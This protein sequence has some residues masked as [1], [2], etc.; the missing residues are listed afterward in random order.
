MNT[1]QPYRGVPSE[2]SI[3][4]TRGTRT[5]SEPL[6]ASVSVVADKL[7]QEGTFP[8]PRSQ[9]ARRS[10]RGVA[11]PANVSALVL[12]AGADTDPN[13]V[14]H[15]PCRCAPH[16]HDELGFSIDAV[17]RS[18]TGSIKPALSRS[19]RLLRDRLRRGVRLGRLG[20][21]PSKEWAGVPLLPDRRRAMDLRF[22]RESTRWRSRSLRSYAPAP[23]P[24]RSAKAFKFRTAPPS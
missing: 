24:T 15:S 23:R 22:R 3:E 20:A 13:Y 21:T 2:G 5:S 16:D 19:D 1:T 4:R 17:D 14:F 12:G 18:C 6:V 11:V 9:P 8:I 7:P 10:R